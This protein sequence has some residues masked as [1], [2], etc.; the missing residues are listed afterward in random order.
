SSSPFTFHFQMDLV[1]L[2]LCVGICMFYSSMW[3]LLS[4]A[5]RVCWGSKLL[6]NFIFVCRDRRIYSG[7]GS[8]SRYG[9]HSRKKGI[10]DQCCKSSGCKLRRTKNLKREL[11]KANTTISSMEKQ[12]LVVTQ[13]D[14]PPL[15]HCQPSSSCSED[16]NTTK[17]STVGVSAPDF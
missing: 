10:V 6:S 15:G 9:P 1:S 7:K 13:E 14:D 17:N 16:P 11:Q 5:T 12:N 3:L 8:W 2:V 4:D